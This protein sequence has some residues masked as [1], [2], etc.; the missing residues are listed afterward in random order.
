MNTYYILDM[1]QGT[2]CVFPT[3]ILKKK[4]FFLILKSQHVE[5]LPWEKEADPGCL[6]PFTFGVLNPIHT[7]EIKWRSVVLDVSTTRAQMG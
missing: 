5:A 6:G 1:E 4:I 2:L 3:T 7:A